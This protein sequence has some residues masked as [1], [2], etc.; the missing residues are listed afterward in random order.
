[1]LHWLALGLVGVPAPRSRLET[2][3]N[4]ATAPV[5]CAR[6]GRDLKSPSTILETMAQSNLPKADEQSAKT[7]EDLEMDLKNLYALA[8][9]LSQIHEEIP[10]NGDR[11]GWRRAFQELNATMSVLES[12]RYRV[13][14]RLIT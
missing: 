8:Q 9:R 11:S 12:V 14:L 4:R 5:S 1:M 13:E 6:T 2:C 7:L 3:G 10:A